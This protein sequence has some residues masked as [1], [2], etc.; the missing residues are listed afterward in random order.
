[1]SPRST[2]TPHATRSSTVPWLRRWWLPLS[3]AVVGVLALGAIVYAATAPADTPV[4]SART[5]GKDAA[6]QSVRAATLDGKQATI[7]AAGKPT[8]AYFYAVGCPSCAEALDNI[9]AS[10]ESAPAGTVYQVVNI[11]PTDS[12]RVIRSFLAGTNTTGVTLLRDSGDQQLSAT[13]DVKVLGTTVVFDSAGREVWRGVDP[14]AAA[15]K[16]ALAKADR[17]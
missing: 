17:Q 6:T 11:S 4:T 16:A 15:L 2:H 9:A 14:S 8:V 12:P 1:M 3:L 13:F 5:S 7:P 10:R